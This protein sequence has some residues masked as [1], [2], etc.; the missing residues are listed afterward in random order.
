MIKEQEAG[1]PTAEV[2]RKH[3]LSPSVCG[4]HGGLLYCE[5]LGRLIS[6]LGHDVRLNAPIYVKPFV[7]V[8]TRTIM[9][10]SS[11]FTKADIDHILLNTLAQI[12]T[13]N[14]TG[15]NVENARSNY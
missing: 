3:G 6:E 11:F 9:C 5:P 4:R 2:C 1:M 10:T 8:F 7:S 12:I 14:E 13:P 15:Y